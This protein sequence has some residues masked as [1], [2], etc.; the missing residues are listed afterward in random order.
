MGTHQGKLSNTP[1]ASSRPATASVATIGTAMCLFG[2][3]GAFRGTHY[4]PVRNCSLVRR[5][6]ARCSWRPGCGC[7]PP[8][9]RR[10]MRRRHPRG[11]GGAP[12][13]RH[14]AMSRRSARSTFRGRMPQPTNW[15]Y[16]NGFSTLQPGKARYGLMLREG[17]PVRDGTVVHPVTI[18]SPPPPPM[19]AGSCPISSSAT[20]HWPELD[21][22]HVLVTH[23]WAQIAV[24]GPNSRAPCSNAR[25]PRISPIAPSPISSGAGDGGGRRAKGRPSGFPASLPMS[26]RCWPATAMT[27]R[28]C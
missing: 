8:R 10:G 9:G 27:W 12:V 18:S 11:L 21:A 22:V 16:C 1:A 23:L 6:W 13:G 28:A 2:A 5:R 20:R 3:T 26:C 4:Q 14:S 17:L 19:P 7:A 24:A 25:S 15:L